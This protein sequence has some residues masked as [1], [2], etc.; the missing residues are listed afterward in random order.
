M[1]TIVLFARV[2][3]G[4]TK[5]SNDALI[6][7]F[8]NVLAMMTGNASYT[9]PS[10]T[11]PTFQAALDAF[12]TAVQEAM[13]GDRVKISTRRDARVTLLSFGRNLAAYVQGHCNEDVTTLLSS[14]FHAARR[15]SPSVIPIAPRNPRTA[16]GPTSGTVYLRH[17]KSPNATNY[18]VQMA[19]TPAGPFTD[20]ALTTSTR[21]LVEEIVPGTTV[22]LR[23]QAHGAAG[24]S[25]WS[26]VVSRM[27][28]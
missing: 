9:A 18:T 2:L 27:V 13:S 12:R 1:D 8:D 26:T 21:T 22:Y 19:T 28:I 24:S 23:A 14:G 3:L 11:L 17:Q 10:P 25:D 20:Y 7:F 4:F 6:M 15:P 16:A 5:L